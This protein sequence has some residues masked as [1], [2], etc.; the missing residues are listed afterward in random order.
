LV[1]GVLLD[2]SADAIYVMNT[3]GGIDALAFKTGKLRW[4]TV[5]EKTYY[6]PIAVL[7]DRLVARTLDQGKN[8]VAVLDVTR[9]GKLLMNSEPLPFPDWAQTYDWGLG[10]RPAAGGPPAPFPPPFTVAHS[11]AAEE[12]LE[13]CE[14]VIDWQASIQVFKTK[15]RAG[16]PE[17]KA[18]EPRAAGGTFRIDLGTGRVVSKIVEP[19]KLA[20]IE[21]SASGTV[22]DVDYVVETTPDSSGAIV[23]YRR[24]LKATEKSGKVLW[25]HPLMGYSQVLIP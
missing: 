25:K 12:R 22:G 16:D 10:T 9:D 15:P 13:K 2:P 1:G 3:D 19:K 14:L 20:P 11:F 4:K 7:G 6:W 17:P 18:P 21:P 23:N 8:T 5:K 24:T